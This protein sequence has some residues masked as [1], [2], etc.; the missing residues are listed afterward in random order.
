MEF[1]TTRVRLNSVVLPLLT[2]GMLGMQLLDPSKIWQALI[3]AFGGL[4]LIAGLWAWSLKHYLR[5]TR[6]VRFTWAQVGDA[7]EE[8][9]TLTNDGPFSA[10]WVEL[11]D[12]STLPGYSAARAT[13]VDNQFANVW[14]TTGTCQRRGVYELGGTTLRSGDPFGIYSVEIFLPEKS[15]LVVM[16]P[17]IPLPSVEIMP[18]GWMG[19]G[20]PR[21]NIVDQT[22]NAGTVREYVHGDSPKLIHWPTTA[23]HGKFYS[24][25]LDGAPASDW[26]I[27]LDVDSKVQ[28][29]QGWENTT[30]LGIILAASLADRVLRARH[31]QAVGLIASGRQTVWLKPQS[32]ERH[33]FEV[34]HALAMLESGHL[35]LSELLERAN[36]KLGNRTSLIVITPS[37]KSD[38]LPPLTHLFW[39]GITPTVLLMDPSSFDAR[40]SAD[41]LAG[42]L[43]EM[44]IPRFILNRSLLKQPEAHPGWR[45]QWGWRITPSGRAISTRPPGDLTWKR[46]G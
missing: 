27:V 2:L 29:G 10:T 21:P 24:R 33:R 9:F 25:Q 19:D 36:P 18:A 26:W 41:S 23:R 15:T 37:I 45:G 7:L 34:F 30:E 14:R 3:V 11:I 13:G 12:H 44:G 32:G 42:T 20:R 8:Q 6:E 46:L 38:W 40:Q 16:P 4:W 39:K 43:A 22:V 5:L 35:P 17:V 1:M 28:V 31:P